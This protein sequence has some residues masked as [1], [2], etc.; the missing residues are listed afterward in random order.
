MNA[1]TLDRAEAPAQAGPEPL[2]ELREQ[3]DRVDHD[4]VTALAARFRLAEQV[5]T[6]K[7][8]TGMLPLDPRREAEIVRSVCDV[9]RAEGIPDEGVRQIFWAV[10]D[11]CGEG[12]LKRHAS[13]DDGDA[14]IS[15]LVRPPLADPI[16]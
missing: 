10:I 15:E 11:Y 3:I 12:V 8:D 1:T 9:A 4:L 16:G 13:F 7:R 14:A 2:T 5:G 6:L